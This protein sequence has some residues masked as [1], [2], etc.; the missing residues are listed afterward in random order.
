MLRSKTLSATRRRQL[1]PDQPF[2]RAADLHNI[3]LERTIGAAAALLHPG[4]PIASDIAG[5]ARPYFYG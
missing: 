2:Q 1:R 4:R 5:S 3:P